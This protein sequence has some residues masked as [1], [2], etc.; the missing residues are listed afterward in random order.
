[1]KQTLTFR[2]DH[3]FTIVQFTDVHFIEG[4]EKDLRTRDLIVR[5]MEM[6][7]PDLIVFTGDVVEANRCPDPIA[8]FREI[9]AAVEQSG[10]PWAVVYGNHDTEEKI[11]RQELM[12]AVTECKNVLAESGPANI[13]GAGNYV[14]KVADAN[15][16]TAAALYFLDSG[17][18]S[19]LP[20][21]NGYGWIE[22]GQINWYMQQSRELTEQNGGNPL[23]ALAFFHIP[24]P[25]YDEVWQREVCCGN[26]LEDVCCPKINTGFFSAMVEMGDVIGTFAGHDHVNDYC[27]TLHGIKLCYG[28]ATGYN[29]YGRDEFP[30]GARV[31]RMH[32]G[33]REFESWLRLD[34]GSVVTEQPVHQPEQGGK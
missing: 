8:A 30:R 3:T 29:T 7:K 1:M 27:G 28:R 25:E 22:R 6:E 16:R 26:K 10:I 19:T 13:G 15:G 18:V 11:T 9:A 24:L 34:D 14:L 5:V 12:Q 17:S 32:A 2:P 4:N 31:I 33:E 20:H 21:V 23:P